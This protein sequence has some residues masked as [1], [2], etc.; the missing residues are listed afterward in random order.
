MN[1]STNVCL[2]IIYRDKLNSLE[3]DLI[4][5][6]KKRVEECTKQNFKD[7]TFLRGIIMTLSMSNNCKQ[8]LTVYKLKYKEDLCDEIT[9]KCT[10]TKIRNYILEPLINKGITY[11]KL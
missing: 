3:E 9:L 6:I 2:S 7:L 11:K 10:R 8:I 5:D 1:D 4:L